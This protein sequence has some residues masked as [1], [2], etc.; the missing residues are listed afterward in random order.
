ML[1][2]DTMGDFTDV[3]VPPVS[4]KGKHAGT[5]SHSSTHESNWTSAAATNAFS[6]SS[7]NFSQPTTRSKTTHVPTPPQDISMDTEYQDPSSTFSRTNL[8][9]QDEGCGVSRGAGT[10]EEYDVMDALFEVDNLNDVAEDRD[11]FRAACGGWKGGGSLGSKGK[12]RASGTTRGQKTKPKLCVGGEK[13][14]GGG[15]HLQ[16]IF[17]AH[18]FPQ[19]SEYEIY[20]LGWLAIVLYPSEAR[21]VIGLMLS[22]SDVF[23]ATAKSTSLPDASGTRAT[24]DQTR[25]HTESRV[26]S[27][28][29]G[30][31]M[32]ESSVHPTAAA[33]WQKD[34]DL[35]QS[36]HNMTQD[37]IIND[38]GF[39]P[40]TP[41]A[42]KVS[43]IHFS[44]IPR[45]TPSLAG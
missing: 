43:I 21:L 32:A 25:D 1:E 20:S 24:A 14:T 29:H 28:D 18:D 3:C 45:L 30:T 4:R 16:D 41:P 31:S 10:G 38:S 6:S 12:E 23:K 36:D 2:E 11:T 27:S 37:S 19:E 33:I 35:T 22:S 8:R 17:G 40:S 5:E 13:D 42:K 9:T 7:R 34:P 15:S 26:Q 44:H 39:I